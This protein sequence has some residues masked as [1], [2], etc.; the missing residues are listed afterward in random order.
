MLFYRF[1]RMIYKAGLRP[2]ARLLSWINRFLFSVWLPASADLGKNVTLAYWG[3][4]VIVHT[5]T[6]MGDG[7]MIGQNVTIG[8]NFGDT[9][10]PEFGRNV[11]IG[12]GS[13]IFGEIYLGDNVVIGSNSVVNKSFPANS[14]VAGNPARIIGNTGGK[15]YREIDA[16]RKTL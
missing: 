8:R 15:N 4:G 2:V 16:E 10:V 11:Y 14:I 13:V 1:N 6:K 7:C 3:L 12:A 5:A 9:K